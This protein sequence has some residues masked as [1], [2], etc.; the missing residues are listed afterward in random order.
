MCYVGILTPSVCMYVQYILYNVYALHFG[1]VNT[2]LHVCIGMY[3]DKM[4]GLIDT[5][6]LDGWADGLM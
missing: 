2:D 5:E 4:E 1:G 3:A 6:M